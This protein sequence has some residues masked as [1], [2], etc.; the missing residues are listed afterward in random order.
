MAGY[1][2]RSNGPG[3]RKGDILLSI[4][5]TP[6]KDAVQLKNFLIERT[7]P[8]QRVAVKVL[9]GQTEQLLYVTLGKA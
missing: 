9:R 8:G 4:E 7:T 6:I 1:G 3:I 2:L 5:N